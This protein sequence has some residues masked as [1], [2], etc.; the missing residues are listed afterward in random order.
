MNVAV[1]KNHEYK[2]V[3]SMNNEDVLNRLKTIRDWTQIILDDC[4]TAERDLNEMID[5]LNSMIE[6][7][8]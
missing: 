4:R 1:A 3:F 8:E 6:E 2:G 5:C 7:D